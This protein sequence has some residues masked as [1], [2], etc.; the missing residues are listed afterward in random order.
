MVKSKHKT[1]A[2][3]CGRHSA[4][5]R[6]VTGFSNVHHHPNYKSFRVRATIEHQV[7]RRKG[8][9][10]FGPHRRRDGCV[11]AII[12]RDAHTAQHGVHGGM[13]GGVPRASNVAGCPR[14]T[15]DCEHGSDRQ[16]GSR[17]SPTRA[18][19]ITPWCDSVMAYGDPNE[20]IKIGGWCWWMVGRCHWQT[21]KAYL[22][23]QMCLNGSIGI[24]SVHARTDLEESHADGKPKNRNV[25]VCRTVIWR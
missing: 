15:F 17:T 2:R 20:N 16:C 9:K 25:W 8:R 14:L 12:I 7:L 21:G 4:T 6:A 24:L 23:L 11:A 10:L 3:D 22:W 1:T 19:A 13:S 5:G 18:M